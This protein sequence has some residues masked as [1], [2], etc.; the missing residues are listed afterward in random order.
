M[1]TSLN[2]VM[3]IEKHLEGTMTGPELVAFKTKM[4]VNSALETNVSMQSRLISLLRIYHRKKVKYQLEQ[5]H[6]HL[7]KTDF[8]NSIQ[9]IF[10]P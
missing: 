9:S 7:L 8:R 5:V 1:K 2:E 4:E 3:T 10:N 6:L